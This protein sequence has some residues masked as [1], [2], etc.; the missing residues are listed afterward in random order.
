MTTKLFDSWIQT[1]LE[2][3]G[4][5]GVEGG[6]KILS[7]AQS[8]PVCSAIG[9]RNWCMTEKATVSSWVQTPSMS[10]CWSPPNLWLLLC[11]LKSPRQTFYKLPPVYVHPRP[12]PCSNSHFQL[13]FSAYSLFSSRCWWVPSLPWRQTHLQGI[14]L[15]RSAPEVNNNLYTFFHLTVL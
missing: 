9:N 4:K 10:L 14:A 1:Q 5:S 8:A 7:V 12:T 2:G 15:K 13:L 3:M 6:G 11:H